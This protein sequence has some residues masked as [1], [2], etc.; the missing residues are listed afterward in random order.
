MTIPQHPSPDPLR[1]P[2]RA[3]YPDTYGSPGDGLSR[4]IE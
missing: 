3:G 4:L 2:Y 1:L